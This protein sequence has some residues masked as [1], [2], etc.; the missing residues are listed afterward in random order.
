MESLQALIGQ[1]LGQ[2]R[3]IE[4]IGEGGMAA[5]FKAYQ[6][7]LNREVAL[8]VLPPYFAQKED[9]VERFVREAQAIGNLHHP[10]ILPVYDTGQD[11]GYSYIAMRYIPHARTL[12]DEMKFPLKMERIIEVMGQ[13]AGALDQAHKAGIIHRDVKPSNVLLDGQWALLSDFGLAKMVEGASELTGTGVGMG[14]PAYMSP[15]QGMGKK[16]DHRTD[17]YALGI[18]L[19]EMLTGSV[20]HRAETPIATVMRRINEPL[21]LPRS[22]NPNI[23]EAVERVL[24]KTLATDPTHRFDSAGEMA[25]A[26]KEAFGPNPDQVLAGVTPAVVSSP[27]TT[28]APPPEPTRL[29]NQP[30]AKAE[31]KSG[32]PINALGF[33]AIGVLIF[34]VLIGIGVLIFLQLRSPAQ[35]DVTQT[36]PSPQTQ[37]AVSAATATPAPTTTPTEAPS[38]T[39]LLEPTPTPAAESDSIA[40]MTTPEAASTQAITPEV[41]PAQVNTPEVAP[42]QAAAALTGQEAADL[43]LAE[44]QKWQAD[45]VLSEIAT[46]G[47]GPLDAEGKSTDWILKFWSPSSKGLNTLMFMNGTFT[48]SPTNLPTPK[49]TILEGVILDTKR[50]YDIGE[51]AGASKFTAEGYRPMA[52]IVPY[53]LDE[54][55]LTWYLNYAGGDFRVV[56]T[57]IIDA[58]SG[59][60][61]Q[62]IALE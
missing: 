32:L 62:A 41:S 48:S 46:S 45:A 17:I 38:P 52:A 33:G 29:S 59:E 30:M 14:T 4:Q 15:E 19:Y 22:I 5:V 18:I 51:K 23:P 53:P 21:P 6:P 50:L 58:R 28:P 35:N 34:L 55:K 37:E 2:Y 43:A 44:A 10:N 39:P 31:S 42:P 25:A 57:V 60:V 49:T 36:T 24:L 9:F 3:I 20:P 61:V 7:G 56:Y 13:I 47:L 1:T 27:K 16:V 26:L 8:K 12:S 40:I 11:K 54:T